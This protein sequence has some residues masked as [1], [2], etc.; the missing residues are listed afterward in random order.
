MARGWLVVVLALALSVGPLLAPEA[1][2][3]SGAGPAPRTILQGNVTGMAEAVAPRPGGGFVLAGSTASVYLDALGLAILPLDAMVA[4]YDHEG[5]NVWVRTLD[6]GGRDALHGVAVSPDGAV[7]AAG[8]SEAGPG[9]WP[10]VASWDREGAFRWAINVTVDAPR[11]VLEGVVLDGGRVIAVGGA[12]L[13]G[14]VRPLL[15]SVDPGG[16]DLRAQV[17]ADPR[18]DERQ[19]FAAAR[20]GNGSLA[21]AGP[22]GPGAGEVAQV[23][24]SADL[25]WSQATV[26][27]LW[28]DI[29]GVGGAFATT[30]HLRTDDNEVFANTSLWSPEGTLLWSRTYGGPAF[31]ATY[32]GMGV[33]GDA[34]GG[35]HVAG[36]NSSLLASDGDPL[37]D[38]L[39]ERAGVGFHLLL[40]EYAADGTLLEAL[41][42]CD[43]AGSCV[44]RGMAVD[45]TG[46][47][48]RIVAVG[49]RM[50]P[51]QLVVNP[52]VVLRDL[53]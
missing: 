19:W 21:V 18:T 10:W 38:G 30:G 47:A 48:A 37:Q 39:L 51:L 24:A 44:G 3:R 42:V 29:A 52:L 7:F 53:A 15:V 33:A 41:E 50:D 46:S 49:S 31:S 1:A 2:P 20:M 5:R 43:P 8:G 27:G 11:A 13:A 4:A 12:S 32:E 25:G 36:Y 28:Y 22:V 26:T 34:A 35:V 40:L 45:E 9:L 14:D 23:N 6:L 17:V 16:S